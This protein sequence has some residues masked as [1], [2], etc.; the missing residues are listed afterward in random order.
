MR[1]QVLETRKSL[2][3]AFLFVFSGFDQPSLPFGMSK[4]SGT[5]SFRNVVESSEIPP[6]F[7]LPV[8]QTESILSVLLVTFFKSR[9]A[10]RLTFFLIIAACGIFSKFFASMLFFAHFCASERA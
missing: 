9:S 4:G 2:K 5:S 10:R 8:L 6:P 1:S 3:V 7:T